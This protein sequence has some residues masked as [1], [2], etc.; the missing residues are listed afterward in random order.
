MGRRAACVAS[1]TVRASGDG[2]AHDGVCG[3]S[4]SRTVLRSMSKRPSTA[5]RV[6]AA[7]LLSCPTLAGCGDSTAATA[8]SAA[9][10]FSIQ[11]PV[12]SMVVAQQRDVGVAWEREIP[13]D[14]QAQWTVRPDSIVRLVAASATGATL[15]A[16][17]VGTAL[18]TLTVTSQ[19]RAV[20]RDMVVEVSPLAC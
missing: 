1:A 10:A 16:R 17:R 9:L 13:A 2:P 14:A 11:P 3:P 15:E 18:V 4:P 20:A 12:A 7:V 8:A 5:R 6:L 19:G